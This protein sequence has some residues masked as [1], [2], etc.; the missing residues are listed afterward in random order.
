[1]AGKEYDGTYWSEWVATRQEKNPT[2]DRK[3]FI[4]VCPSGATF[5]RKHNPNIPHTPEENAREAIE[6]Y[7]EGAC[8]AH[9]HT[10][11]ENGN[12]ATTFERL[13][14]TAD[15]IL[16]KCPDMLIAPS[17]YEGLDPDTPDY[18]FEGVQPMV[19]ALHGVNPRY[20][21][22]TI[23]VPVSY[24]QGPFTT[25]ATEENAVKTIKLLDAN[26]VKP[27][28]MMHNWE[29]IYNV[30]EWL[31]R[32][33]ILK[34]PY[35][36]TLGPGMHNACETY[37]DPWGMMYTIGM[38][39]MM[40]AVIPE[41][42]TVTGISCGGRNWLPITTLTLMLGVDFV[43]VG[44]EDHLWVYPHKNEKIRR[45]ADMVKK[46]ATIARELGREIGTPDEARKLLKID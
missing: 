27:E 21:Q 18:S 46:I 28:F 39:N 6:S 23:F 22:S 44:M 10:R 8:M 31:V 15:M 37:P 29:G 7:N 24:Q 13:K 41:E 42:D 40:S 35:F 38:K 5:S 26:N 20:M 12:P 33:Q 19:D 9:I 25:I 43:R 36:L 34:K 16:D 2:M 3:V 45:N 4:T 17:S 32:P 11:D 30:K 14:E 1:M